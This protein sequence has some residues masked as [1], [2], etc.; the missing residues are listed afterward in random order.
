MREWTQDIEATLGMRVHEAGRL[1]TGRESF[2]QITK[3]ATFCKGP[4]T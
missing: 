3:R 2:G 4:S 1:A